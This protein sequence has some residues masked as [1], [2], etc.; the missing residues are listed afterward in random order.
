MLIKNRH[1][2]YVYCYYNDDDNDDDDDDFQKEFNRLP[3]ILWDEG[4]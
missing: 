2:I 3:S 4:E 1:H